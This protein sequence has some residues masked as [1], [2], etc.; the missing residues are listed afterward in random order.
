MLETDLDQ[1][2][3]RVVAAD[4][5]RPLRQSVLRP[6][7]VIEEM[8]YPGDN[9]PG[10]FHLAGLDASGEMQGIASFY[11]EPHPLQ[12]HEGDWRLRGMAVVP[13]LQGKGLGGRLV[14]VG[15]EHIREQGGRRLWC[16]ARVSAQRFYERIGFV[17][18]G[19][20]FE[21][22]TIGP[23]YVMSIAVDPEPR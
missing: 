6:H 11:V 1:F 4:R 8:V 14:A 9:A 21:I 13:S 18:E 16:N 22:P 2:E 23:H 5:V 3:I 17:A 10:S 19:E 20:S 15:L 7:Q 12:P